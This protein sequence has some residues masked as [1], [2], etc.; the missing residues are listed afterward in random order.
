MVKFFISI[1]VSF[2]CS[3]SIYMHNYYLNYIKQNTGMQNIYI[4]KCD[5]NKT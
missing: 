3:Y 1:V 2:R 5:L 4:W